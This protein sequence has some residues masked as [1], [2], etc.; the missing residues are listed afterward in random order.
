MCS[1]FHNKDLAEKFLAEM[2]MNNIN[3]GHLG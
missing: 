1:I 2:E 3:I